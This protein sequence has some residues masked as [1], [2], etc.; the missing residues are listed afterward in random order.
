LDFEIS[1]EIRYLIIVQPTKHTKESK[2]KINE[3]WKKKDLEV[4]IIT[5]KIMFHRLHYKFFVFF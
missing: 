4:R 1:L 2:E 3:N 5:L